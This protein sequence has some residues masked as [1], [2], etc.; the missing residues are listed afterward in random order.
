MSSGET[1]QTTTAEAESEEEKQSLNRQTV[2]ADQIEELDRRLRIVV[3]TLAVEV[4]EYF[5]HEGDQVTRSVNLG[6]VHV[7]RRKYCM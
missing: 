5:Q 3:A 4:V 2:V 7:L 6:L 1:C